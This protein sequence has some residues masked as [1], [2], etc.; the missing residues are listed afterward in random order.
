MTLNP[1]IFHFSTRLLTVMLSQP[2][3]EIGRW[4][5]GKGCVYQI[6]MT[7]SFN[8]SPDSPVFLPS[9]N[10]SRFVQFPSQEWSFFSHIMGMEFCT[11]FRC[12]CGITNKN[13]CSVGAIFCNI[14]H[15]FFSD[16]IIKI[17][18]MSQNFRVR[19]SQSGWQ[20]LGF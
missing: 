18:N 2:N 10:G 16:F 5:W 7:T 4:Q 20:Q 11:S 6:S 3:Y 14:L 17:I 1:S 13:Q 8:I 15:S 9:A 12:H 19:I